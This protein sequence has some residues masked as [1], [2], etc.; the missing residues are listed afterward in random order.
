MGLAYL[1]WNLTQER[2]R[3]DHFAAPFRFLLIFQFIGIIIL[4]LLR[5][6]SLIFFSHSKAEVDGVDT[7]IP[8]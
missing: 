1:C 4:F 7:L 3:L 8:V 5:L 2:W 6:F